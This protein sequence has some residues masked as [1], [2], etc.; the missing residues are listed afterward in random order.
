MPVHRTNPVMCVFLSRALPVL[1]VAALS[2]CGGG[3]GGGGSSGGGSLT[4]QNF[5]S[6]GALPTST[7]VVIDGM[8]ATLTNHTFTTDD[9]NST[10][11]VV[12]DSRT[13]AGLRGFSFTTPNTS[14][15]WTSSSGSTLNC[16]NGV[17]GL[18]NPGGTTLGAVSD[19]YHSSNN[20][21]YQSFGIWS[22]PSG[23][24]SAMSYG[25]PTPVSA[26]PT[27]GSATYTG[28]LRG[29]YVSKGGETLN[30][31]PVSNGAQFGVRAALTADVTFSSG[32]GTVLINTSSTVLEAQNNI[33][34]ADPS[35]D[36]SGNLTIAPGQNLFQ[37]NIANGHG[38][39]GDAAGRFYGPPP[40][41][42]SP[43][44]L[45]GTV[46]LTGP[47]GSMVGAFGAKR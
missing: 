16:S 27:S 22:V 30:G 23:S 12:Y 6:W 14:A 33:Q 37:G 32:T 31:D 24:V 42:Q 35:F 28:S 15:N 36:L 44:E 20:W 29:G 8:S 46:Q 9:A 18:A 40:S 13:S 17:C 39:S 43:P 5:T 3:G 26:L 38:M 11:G 47:N 45:G 25:A 41:S 21:N 19:P 4:P 34:F 1:T 7:P 10:A 2:A